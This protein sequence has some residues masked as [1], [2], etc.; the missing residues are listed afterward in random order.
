MKAT[1][2]TRSYF[3]LLELMVVVGIIAILTSILLPALKKIRGKADET[4][5]SSNLKQLGLAMAFYV[6]DNN[7]WLPMY[8]YPPRSADWRVQYW[9]RDFAEYAQKHQLFYCP[10]SPDDI[11]H[12]N[13]T[14]IT[15]YAFAITCGH[16]DDSGNPCPSA[17]YRCAVKFGRVSK[18]SEAVIIIDGTFVVC[19]PSF[20]E[21]PASTSSIDPRH[22]GEAMSLYLD[23]HVDRRAVASFSSY[24]VFQW[25]RYTGE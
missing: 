9:P 21:Y 5:C 2:H 19:T 14:S 15:N 25:A 13:A 6:Q 20:F 18:P 7:D 24:N 16:Y 10:S 4:I 8:R 1:W 12:H 11:T 22:S 3:T 23:A 17:P